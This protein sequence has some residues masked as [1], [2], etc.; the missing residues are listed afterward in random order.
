MFERE[1]FELYL[2]FLILTYM[3]MKSDSFKSREYMRQFLS[4]FCLFTKYLGFPD[5]ANS[6]EPAAN[7]G[8]LR[9]EGLI[10]GSGR[11]PGGR[12]GKPL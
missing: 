10:P 6:K 4:E 9:D 12:H 7:A 5:G 11:H 2:Y 1:G 8:D 3:N